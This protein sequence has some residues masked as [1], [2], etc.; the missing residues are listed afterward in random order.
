MATKIP[1]IIFP[2]GGNGR[3]TLS[4][5][6]RFNQCSKTI[7]NVIGFVDDDPLLFGS[8]ISNVKIFDRSI[9]YKHEQARVI[10]CPGS[11]SNFLKRKSLITELNVNPERFLT[12]IDPSAI[13]GNDCLLGKNSVVGPGTVLTH[14]VVIGDHCFIQSNAVLSHDV[15]IEDYCLIGAG[16]TLAGESKVGEQSYIGAGVNIREKISIGKGALVGLGSVVIRDVLPN[17]VVAGV[18]ARRIK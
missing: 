12:L 1:L 17:D 15:K 7:F 16:V 11:P 6:T 4:I 14:G 9:L 10:A 2:A 18:P 5:V 13:I 8:L 3:E